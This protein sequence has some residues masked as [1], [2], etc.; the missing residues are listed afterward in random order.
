MIF[1]NSGVMSRPISEAAITEPKTAWMPAAAVDDRHHGGDAGK[2]DALNQR[3]LGSEEPDADGLQD[4]GEAADEEAGGDQQADV[5]RRHA[6]GGADDQRRGDD[7]AV[8][9]ED[10]LE[11]VG[12][13]ASDGEALV[14]GAVGRLRPVPA[15]Q[16][17]S[18]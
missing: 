3:E 4:G 11:A 10:V 16:P 5:L 15:L 6:G 13:G 14:F 17:I 7:A 18:S 2:G 9:G 1:E 12:E 8:H